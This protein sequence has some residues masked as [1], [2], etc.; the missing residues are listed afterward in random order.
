MAN[1]RKVRTKDLSSFGALFDAFTQM[2]STISRMS[3]RN[4]YFMDSY[5]EGSLKD[6]E[7]QR[8]IKVRPIELA[9]IQDSTPIPMDMN[10]FWSSSN[11]K[12][13]LEKHLHG[14]L[15]KLALEDPSHVE[16]V[17]SQIQPSN[18]HP[19]IKVVQEQ[20][21]LAHLRSDMD[22]ADMRIIPHVMDAVSCGN[23][24]VVVLSND[25]DVIVLLLYYIDVFHLHGLKQLW[26]R[27]GIGDSTRFIPLHTLAARMSTPLSK[28]LPAIHSLTGCD[29]TSKMGTKTAALKCDPLIHLAEFGK[30]EKANPLILASAEEYLVRVLKRATTCKTFTEL[31]KEIHHHSKKSIMQQL[32]PT[33]IAL[34]QHLLWAHLATFQM[35]HLLD[36]SEA[37]PNPTEFGYIDEDGL[38]LPSKKL[39]DVPVAYTVTCASGKCARITC[40]CREEGVRCCRFCRCRKNN[41]VDW[42]NPII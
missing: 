40:S 35:V 26:V 37:L 27:A 13:L 7:R 18:D 6:S 2:T 39:N 3:G 14:R 20:R 24:N 38:L 12:L 19:C 36:Y 1:I 16:V 15:V 31:R 8:R 11:N 9:S 4:H 33:T 29:T 32:P 28:V 25:T 21:E 22:E 34:Q 5:H 30:S 42:K 17:V 41:S 23:R 10:T